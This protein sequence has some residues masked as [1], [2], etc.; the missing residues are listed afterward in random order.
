[1]GFEFGSRV[2]KCTARYYSALGMCHWNNAYR[3][4]DSSGKTQDFS[5]SLRCIGFLDLLFLMFSVLSCKV[6]CCED[7]RFGKWISCMSGRPVGSR[8]FAGEHMLR[9]LWHLVRWFGS[10][11]LE[12]PTCA[13]ELVLLDTPEHLPVSIRWTLKLENFWQSNR[14]LV[15]RY[16]S[17]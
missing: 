11:W 8:S 12:F 7:L 3:I 17:P 4:S 14:Q 1:M 10:T 2:P 13:N 6:I 9:K 16:L 5:L 15:L